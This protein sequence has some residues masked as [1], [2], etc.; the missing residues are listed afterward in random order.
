MTPYILYGGKRSPFVRRV[1]IWLELQQ[2]AFERREVG[3]FG[4]DFE[5]FKA[6]N[7]LGRVPALTI[8]PGEH[9]IETAAIIDFLE[10]TAPPSRRLI[11]ATGEPRRM[12]Q[13]RI[14]LAHAVAEKGVALVYETERRPPE[15]RWSDWRARLEAQL[16]SGLVALEA[17]VHGADWLGGDTPDGA[18]IA[19]VAAY[20]FIGTIEAVAL[21]GR[22]P[23][24]AALSAR[25]NAQA[26]FA[27]SLPKA[28]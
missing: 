19:A 18:D 10:D 22:F 16:E 8:A 1:A 4:P 2:R 24:L 25:A 12:C 9:L 26:E 21:A 14:G 17:V 13:Q 15:L 23:R 11:P 6:I 28:M 3:L 5:P 27:A 7:P 20:D